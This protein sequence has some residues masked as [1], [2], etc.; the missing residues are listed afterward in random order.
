M[1]V[2]LFAVM[3]HIGWGAGD[4]FGTIGSR[5]T[6]SFNASFWITILT[7]IIFGL[8]LPFAWGDLALFTVP[9]A[10]LLISISIL[11]AI[12]FA[13]SNEAY[14]TGNPTL[15]GTIS[16]SFPALVVIFSI[17]FLKETITFLQLLFIITIFTGVVISSLDFTS[18]KTVFK[19]DRSVMYALFAWLTWGLEFTFLKIPTRQVGWYFSAYIP[20]FVGALTFLAIN[21]FRKEIRPF[22]EGGVGWAYLLGALLIGS[23]PFWFNAAIATGNSS[24]VAPIAGAY[25]ALFALLSY[26]VFRQPITRQQKYGIALTLFGIIALSVVSS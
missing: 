5:K 21:Y 4:I 8:Y 25:P 2:I 15:V 14:K 9:V 13:A 16:G 17:L 10:L 26:F 19:V 1:Q 18:L 11:M 22:K 20:A 12:S 23:G 3:A 24:I 7:A 6:N